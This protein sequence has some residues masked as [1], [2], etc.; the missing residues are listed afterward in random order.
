MKQLIF[1]F[2][3]QFFKLNHKNFE[4]IFTSSEKIFTSSENL[5]TATQNLLTATKK[6]FTATDNLLDPSKKMLTAT[7]N[8]LTATKKLLT[9]SEKPYTSRENSDINSVKTHFYPYK[10]PVFKQLPTRFRKELRFGDEV[11]E[12]FFIYLKTERNKNFHVPC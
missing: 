3:L 6:S 7:E 10:N 2:L 11:F 9:A 12:V 4:K 1:G 8:L 5:L